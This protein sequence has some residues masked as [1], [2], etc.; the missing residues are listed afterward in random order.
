MRQTK[1]RSAGFENITSVAFIARCLALFGFFASIAPVAA[2]PWPGGSEI[3][4][5][6]SGATSDLSGA[7]WNPQSESL[8]VMRQNRQ[9]WEFAWN[10]VSTNFEL[11]QTGLLPSGIGGD[12]EAIAQ[13]DHAVFD[14]VYTLSEN[15]G[16]IAR[17][18]DA[19]GSPSVLRVWNLEVT[20]NGHALPPETAG[21]G[22]EALEFVPDTALLEAG[23]QFPDGSAFAG[24]TKGM[25]GLLFVGHQISGRLHVFDVNPDIS[26]DF[27]NHGSFLTAAS[28]IAGLHFDRTS[29]LMFI[30]HNPSNVNSL[31]ISTLSS[32]ATIG[33]I[34]ADEIYDSAMP[35]GNLEGLAVVSRNQCGEFGSL[36]AERSLFLTRDGGSQNLVYFEQEPCDC[37]GSANQDEFET[38]A[39][40]GSL[41]GGCACLD[42]D[43]DGDVDCDDFDPPL[44]PLCGQVPVPGLPLTGQL[45]LG[46]SVLLVGLVSAFQ[47]RDNARAQEKGS[48]TSFRR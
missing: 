12:V 43:N 4:I 23:F 1:R 41:N 10:P 31:E 27:V 40:S 38:C 5:A 14:E 30:W 9:V 7:T 44:S 26:E 3:S 39:A 18:I 32:N 29:A 35:S 46:L 48:A 34:D 20:N 16:R 22:A 19:D 2:S 11:L 36:P 24:S 21:Q 33:T 13:V 47:F 15:E 8:W 28:E 37:T 17:V 42:I 25:G 6:I 45:I